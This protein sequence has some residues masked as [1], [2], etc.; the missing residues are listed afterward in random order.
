MATR[1]DEITPDI[2][3]IST[4]EP[5]TRFQFNQFLVKDDEPLLFHTGMRA[6][7][8]A[9]RDAVAKVIDPAALRWISFSHFEPDE[10]GSLNEW[11][12]LAPNA[13][14]LS[15][16]VGVNV[17]LSDFA[18]RPARVM[19]DDEVLATG[20]RRL[21][22]LRTPHVPHAWE[23]LLLFEETGR[24]LFCSDLFSQ[25]GDDGPLIN[26]GLGERARASLLEFQAGP[27]A[28]YLPYTPQTD[29]IIRR[30]AGLKPSTL[31]IM[32]GASF[33]GDGASA[34]LELA[35]LFKEVLG[36]RN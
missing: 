22:F 2:Y 16:F 33:A 29:P 35:Q 10:C 3:R 8:P 12:A 5:R 28:N 17:I 21:R 9:V 25:G 13:Q 31:A 15:S 18:I 24:T 14:A 1:I 20:K 26:S 32:H 6:M 36:G 23:A 4:Y 27:M 11:L 7:F 34:L 30:L 19:N